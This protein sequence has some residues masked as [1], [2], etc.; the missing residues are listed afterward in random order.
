MLN[1]LKTKLKNKSLTNLKLIKEIKIVY[2]LKINDKMSQLKN[3][4]NKIIDF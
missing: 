1:L 2:F 3:K 4:M